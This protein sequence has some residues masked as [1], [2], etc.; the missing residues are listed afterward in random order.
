[1]KTIASFANGAI[2]ITEENG[3]MSLNF[4]EA[5]SLGGGGATGIVKIQGKGSVA[6]DG[7][8][9]LKLGEALAISHLPVAVQP[10]AEVLSGVI[11]QAVKALE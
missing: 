9:A 4:D 7:E 3:A 6:L 11:N 2:S 8:L 5:A 10:L 1:M